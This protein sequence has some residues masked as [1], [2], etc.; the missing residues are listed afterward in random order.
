MAKTFWFE[1][2][3]KGTMYTGTPQEKS[4]IVENVYDKV[5]NK[6]DRRCKFVRMETVVETTYALY[7]CKKAKFDSYIGFTISNST[8]VI[9]TSAKDN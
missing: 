8:G 5:F 1:F 7:D 4:V 6:V 2:V 9:T 3:R